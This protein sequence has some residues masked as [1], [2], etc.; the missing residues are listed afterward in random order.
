[1]PGVGGRVQPEG[2]VLRGGACHCASGPGATPRV[3]VGT[4]LPQC[5]LLLRCRPDDRRGRVERDVVAPAAAV[6]DS[7]AE[8]DR[9]GE[10]AAA[11]VVLVDPALRPRKRTRRRQ[12]PDA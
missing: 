4:S 8:M 3:S 9:A 12:T 2:R 7:M 10:V 1:A 11:V 6:G 5:S